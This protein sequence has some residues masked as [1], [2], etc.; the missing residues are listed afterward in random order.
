MRL[1]QGEGKQAPNKIMII[2]STSFFPYYFNPD[3]EEMINLATV[4]I[5]NFLSYILHH[6]VCPEYKENIGE[7]RKSCDIVTK[8]LWKNQQFTANGPGNFNMASSMLFGGYFY[9]TYFDNDTWKNQ[10]DDDDDQA[11][12]TND[13]ARK[14]VKFALAGA[15]SNE[16]ATRFRDLA[17][18]NALTATHIEDIDGFEITA[19]LPPDEETKEFYHIHAP[20]LQPVGKVIANAYRD[21][22]K[23]PIDLTPEEKSE[24]ENG[25]L[26]APSKFEFFLEESLI[27]HC[28]PGMKVITSVWE[29]NCGMHYFDEVMTAYCSIYTVLA[30]D[31]MLG[32]KKPRS[33][34]CGEEDNED[35]N[36]NKDI[37][38]MARD[39]AE[40]ALRDAGL[41]G[42]DKEE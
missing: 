35:G 19:I 25:K 40:K 26:V 10:K 23:P 12:M 41:S 38:K 42:Q 31:L 34:A 14:V 5:R 24:W 7:A 18:Q 17:N 8:E 39:A 6:D 13:I 30:N 4:T 22:G 29:L 36:E 1:Q 21:P 16:Q 20:D 3:T 15:G 2:N 27:Q 28:Y 32:W 33:L 37:E 9:E 11:K